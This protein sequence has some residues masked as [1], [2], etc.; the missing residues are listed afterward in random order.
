M[1]Y[2]PI[3]VGIRSILGDIVLISLP[4]VDRHPVCMADKKTEITSKQDGIV[5]ERGIFLTPLK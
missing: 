3:V 5:I 4:P 2:R 1:G